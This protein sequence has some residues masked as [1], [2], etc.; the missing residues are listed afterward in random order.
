M[1]QN[2]FVDKKHEI[3]HLWDD[4]HGHTELPLACARYAYRKSSLGKFKSLYGD[5]LEKVREYA[6]YG[7][8]TLF[9]SDVQPELKVLLDAYEDSDEPSIGHRI[10]AFDIEVDTEGGFPNF[11]EADK[12]ITAIAIYDFSTDRYYC[13]VLDQDQK[14][15]NNE[16]D[17]VTIKSFLNEGCLL[18]AFINKWEEI[19]PTIVTGWNS[20]KFDI[21]Y[22]YKRI[23]QVLGKRTANNLSSIGI[24]YQNKFNKKMTIA[25]VSCLDYMDLYKKFLGVMKP[26]YALGAVAKDEALQSQKLTYRGSLNELYKTDLNRYIEYNLVDVKI[27]VELDKKYDFIYL[28]RSVCHK[29]HIPYE[30]N[31]MS[32]RFID[33]A[34]LM[35]L[36]RNKLIA[37]NKPIGGREE[38]EEMEKEGEDGFVGAYV[39]EPVPGVYDWICSADITSLYPSVIMSLNISPDTKIGR[40]SEWDSKSF[41]AGNVDSVK[42]GNTSYTK[43]QFNDLLSNN[44]ASVSSNGI[45]YS[46][47][48]VG[49]IPYI[50]DMWFKERMEYRDLARKYKKEGN[51][52]QASFYNRRQLRQKIFL[53]SVYGTL[54]LPVFRFYDKDNAE[55]TTTSGQV[56]IRAAEEL[57]NKIF[58][59]KFEMVGK[60]IPNEDFVK[61]ID[62]DSVYFSSVPLAI[63]EPTMPENME[64]FTIDT[65]T[66]VAN[67]INELYG[68]MVPIEF[69]ISSSNNRIKIIGDVIAKKSMRIA[70]KR[71]AM[72]KVFD[73]ESMTKVVDKDGNEGKLE[74]KG[75]DTVRS[76]FPAAFRTVAARV[77]DMLLRGSSKEEID[78]KILTFEENIDNVSFLDLGK[79]TSVKFV[80]KKGDT[81]YNPTRRHSFQF[82]K[83]TPVGVKAALAYNDLLKVWGLER[84]VEPIYSGQKIKWVYLFQNE[85]NLNALSMKGDETDPDEILE[86]IEKYIDRNSMYKSELKSK[87]AE[88]YQVVKWE[89]PRRNPVQLFGDE[90]G[91]D[92]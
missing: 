56:I 57:V 11:N 4:E 83:K 37:P 58:R 78:E 10:L 70:K 40:L 84:L 88:F 61:Y 30:W 32:S 80:S 85:F 87:L 47:Q 17:N 60:Q 48:K 45:L 12:A 42:I 67:K 75:I 41:R 89:Y 79:A 77:L 7:D 51:A 8:P 9:E 27:I 72:L 18:T 68:T 91:H 69:N 5:T 22:V 19:N 31:Q 6:D 82:E 13:Y 46:Q 74:V 38:Y 43:E 53:N 34:I 73:M 62:T 2:I 92:W 26:S 59:D 35:H 1:Y 24:V 71:Y 64:K 49:V 86:F 52:E 63:C 33:G 90:S 23:L 50:L 21:P 39:K 25:G 14:I 15:P 81:N 66:D 44:S 3:I 29:G 16:H 76:S 20:N 36:H 28:A 54:G 65:I 55:A